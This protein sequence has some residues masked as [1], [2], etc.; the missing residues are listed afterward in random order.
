[1]LEDVSVKGEGISKKNGNFN[2]DF[3]GKTN[4]DRIIYFSNFAKSLGIFGEMDK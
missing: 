4:N 2:V 3:I 1:M